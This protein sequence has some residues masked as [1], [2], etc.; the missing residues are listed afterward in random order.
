M[1]S[2][3]ASGE[4]DVLGSIWMLLDVPWWTDFTEEKMLISLIRLTYV[5][6]VF[7]LNDCCSWLWSARLQPP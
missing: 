6:I 7:S 5:L 3:V 4:S 2:R 1:S